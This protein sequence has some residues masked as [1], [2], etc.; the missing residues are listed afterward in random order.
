MMFQELFLISR[1]YYIFYIFITSFFF[2]A[3]LEADEEAARA[4]ARRAAYKIQTSEDA[5]SSMTSSEFDKFL[6]ERATSGSTRLSETSP[7]NNPEHPPPPRQMKNFIAEKEQD[8][9]FAL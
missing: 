1:S 2:K 5:Q 8:E 6:T 9:M 7:S 4:E 3:Q